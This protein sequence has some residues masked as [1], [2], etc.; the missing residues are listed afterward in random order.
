MAPA[1]GVGLQGLF[2]ACWKTPSKETR[3]TALFLSRDLYLL[4]SNVDRR[5]VPMSN[6]KFTVP[7]AVNEP[8]QDYAPDSPERI[9]LDATLSRMSGEQIDIPVI[10]A[11]FGT[12]IARAP[13]PQ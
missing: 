11:G 12:I 10:I 4:P 8:P 5:P 13:R 7:V 2:W 6:A 9:E 3:V 1:K